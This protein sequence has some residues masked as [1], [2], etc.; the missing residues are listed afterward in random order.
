M[1]AGQAVLYLLRKSGLIL[2]ALLLMT[3]LLAAMPGHHAPAVQSTSGAQDAQNSSTSMPDMPGMDMDDAKLN[4][5]SAVHEMT[6]AHSAM[7]GDAHSLHMQMTAMRP[8]NEQDIERAKEISQQLRNGIEKYQDYHARSTK[9]TKSFF[10]NCRKPNITS[11][12]TGTVF[13]NPSTSIPPG[14]L[15]FFTGKL[16]R[17]TNSLAPCTPCPSAHPKNNSTSAFR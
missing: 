12:I 6:G 1:S 11:P 8:T 14:P 3:V 15:P 9:V 5:Q 10:P 7:H 13:S 4:E 16:P 2:S 17:A